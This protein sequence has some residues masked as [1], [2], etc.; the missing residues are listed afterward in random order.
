[1]DER[2]ERRRRWIAA[3]LGAALLSAAG[4]AQVL[5]PR[6]IEIPLA[7]L[8]DELS[9]RFP[10]GRRVGPG[11]D[12][13]LDEP[14]IGLMTATDRVVVSIGVALDG[15]WLTRPVQGGMAVGFGVAFDRAAQALRAVDVRVETVRLDGLDPSLV[16]LA[17]RSLRP[18]AEALLEGQ[19]LHVLQ[20]RDIE[21]LQAAGLVPGPVRVTPTALVV[22][23][24]AA[25]R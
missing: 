1:M 6:R 17:E 5:A 3:G 21:R 23:L 14:R 15:P 4:C 10:A 2:I 16:R 20:A 25:G 7:R 9:R 12:L 8:Q 11:F 22:E 24:V 18:I 13:R 19:A